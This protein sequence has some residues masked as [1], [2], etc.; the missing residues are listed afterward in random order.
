MG[1]MSWQ[2]FRCQIDCQEYPYDC[3]SEK[4]I[5][6]TAD[7]LILDG[8]R[9]LGYKYIIIDDCWQS[10][11][12]DKNTNEIIADPN[13]FPNGIKNLAKYIHSKN[14]LFGIYLDYGSLTCEHYPGSMNYLEID[15]K[16]LVQWNVDY[17]KMDGCYSPIEKMPNGYEKFSQLINSTG[18]YIIFSCSYPA[19]IPWINNP[20]LIDWIKLQKNCNLWR[21]FGDI[22]DSWSSVV[23]IINAYIITND[24][25]PRIGGPGHWNDPDMLLLGN[26]G[27]SN[28]QKRVQMGMWCMFAAPLLISADMDKLDDISVSLLKNPHLLAINQDKGGHQAEF[29]KK[30]ENNIQLWLRPLDSDPIGWVIACVNLNDGGGPIHIYVSL[31]DFKSKSY[32]IS[33]DRFELLDV[34]NENK[35]KNIEKTK[36]FMIPINP[37]G[38]MMYRVKET[39]L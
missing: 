9:D 30:I 6:R 20:K 31:D 2:R 36:K 29:I 33:G 25:L 24:I 8:W 27:L 38:I 4:L 10:R 18:R 13:R 19:Y 37:S 21:M 22:Q 16:S 3:I 26:Y 23:S 39:T 12:R 17:V 35:M 14:L 28:D 5:Q 34:F 7:K 1:W 15:S 32:T 11:E